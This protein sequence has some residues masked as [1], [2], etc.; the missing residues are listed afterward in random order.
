M[1]LDF[2]HSFNS[3]EKLSVLFKNGALVSLSLTAPP[4]FLG[5]I[6][7]VCISLILAYKRGK[8]IDQYSRFLFV[9]FMSISYLVYIIVFQYFLA[10]E[11][12]LFPI[13]GY[14][15]GFNAIFYVMLPWIIILATTNHVHMQLTNHIA[16]RCHVELVDGIAA[17]HKFAQLTHI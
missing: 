14:R 5:I 13:R 11:W 8:P 4:Y 15:S 9:G 12:G 7:F 3:G 2:G 16:D 1:T 10:F 6:L 17:A